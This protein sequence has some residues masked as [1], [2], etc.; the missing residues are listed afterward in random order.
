MIS[1]IDYSYV[2]PGKAK[3]LKHWHE[4]MYE[5]RMELDVWDGMNATILPVRKSGTEQWFGSGGVVDA[6][7][8]AVPIS[9]ASTILQLG[10]DFGTAQYKDEK[11]VYC[12][13]LIRHWGHFLMEGVS[14]LWY[15]LQNDSSI[16]KYVFVLDENEEREIS[17]N[18]KEFL[19]LFGIWDKLEIINRPTKYRQAIIPEPAFCCRKYYSPR[20]KEIFDAVADHISV[21][22]QWKSPKKIFMSRSQLTKS[23]DVEF[24]GEALDDFY[25]K[26]GYEVIFPE[27]FS[28]SQMIFYIRNAESIA[29]VSGSLPH[30]MLFGYQDQS[31]DILERCVENNDW[32]VGVN[33]LLGLHTTY[34]DSNIPI[35][36]VSMN[37]PLILAFDYHLEQYAKDRGMTFPDDKFQSARYMR[38]LLIKYM[39]SYRK[40]YQYLWYMPE[41]LTPSINSLAEAYQDGL[42]Y[43]GE[44]LSGAKPFQWQHYFQIRYWKRMVVNLIRRQ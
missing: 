17:G 3:E 7:G 8:N 16:D 28:L 26:N 18:Y 41:Y 6:E 23:G 30:N 37:G 10:Y 11:V 2:R 36:S 27:K 43:F 12:G 20:F 9:G 38:K 42:R 40:Q 5:N 25:R 22:S 24:G 33:R 19:V 31:I 34:I 15:Y 14:R 29:S 44:Y 35:Y 21:D 13:Y 1:K 4:T 32:Q 39:K